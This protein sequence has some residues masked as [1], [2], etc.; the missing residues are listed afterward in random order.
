M[1]RYIDNAEA[2]QQFCD[3]LRGSTW[4]ALDTEFLR[5]KT[6]YAKLCLIQVANDDVAACIDPLAIDDLGPLNALLY[7]PG[8]T[9]VFHAAS[10]DLEIFHDL[11]G[12]VPSPVFDTQLAAT[13]GGFG[14]QVS[15]AALVSGILDVQLEKAHS[16]TD[17][18]KRPLSDGQVRYALDDVIYLGQIY[19]ILHDTLQEKG[20]LAWLDDDF[21]ALADKRRYAGPA[22]DAWRKIRGG[23]RL[24]N[25]QLA[26]LERLVK[27]R[28]TRARES[29]RPRKW[30]LRDD[31]LLEIARQLPAADR[32][33]DI[34]GIDDGFIKRQGKAISAL[35]AEARQLPE[36]D[37]PERIEAG[38]RLTL[39][40]EA[41]VDAMMATLRL[42]AAEHSV[43]P[44]ILSTRKDLE[45]FVHGDASIPLLHG[46]RAALAGNAVRGFLQGEVSLQ[47]AEGH[48]CLEKN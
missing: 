47:T 20:R 23:Q 29:D 43:T 17:W 1:T 24:K 16:R 4:L 35:V 26:A 46:W 42:C 36:A 7:D 44:A 19:R 39:V 15:Y 45:R 48:L 38:P 40:Q 32:L 41:L 18:S 37:W 2:L 34:R 3:E 22:P 8:I 33:A 14:D 10:Q 28:E 13:V 31:L 25:A 27:W 9:K 11:N 12:E 6:Y 30:I 21:A 5:E